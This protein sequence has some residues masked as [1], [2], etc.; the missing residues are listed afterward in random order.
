MPSL[1]SKQEMYTMD[2]GDESEDESMS[3]KTLDDIRD[4]SNSHPS[5]NR[6]EAYK[7]NT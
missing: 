4:G 5:I 3:T 2:L 6:R 1:I 7:T